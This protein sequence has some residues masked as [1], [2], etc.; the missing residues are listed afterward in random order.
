MKKFLRNAVIAATLWSA[1][2]GAVSSADAFH[3]R[4]LQ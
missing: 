2:F 1:A 4:A 3:L